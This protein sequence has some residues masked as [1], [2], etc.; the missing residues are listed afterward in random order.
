M[1]KAG[2]CDSVTDEDLRV[3][4]ELA[5]I[6]LANAERELE[7]RMTEKRTKPKNIVGRVNV[8]G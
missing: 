4:I 2:K 7:R 1:K 5:K 8:R 3:F 6:Q